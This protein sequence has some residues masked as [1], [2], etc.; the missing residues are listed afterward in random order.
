[1]TA[2]EMEKIIVRQV[3]NC[4]AS[5]GMCPGRCSG[6]VIEPKG[7]ERLDISMDHKIIK[8]IK[9]VMLKNIFSRAF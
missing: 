7:Q 5:E 4:A 9:S 6:S 8:I 3:L 2:L 1:M